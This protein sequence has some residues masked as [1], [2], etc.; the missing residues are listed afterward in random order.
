MAADSSEPRPIGAPR[1]GGPARRYL[2][3]TAVP[4]VTAHPELDTPQ[5]AEDV[6]R[7][8]ELFLGEL[9]YERAVPLGLDPGRDRLTRALR[10]FARSPDRR[11]EDYL[12]CYIAAHGVVSPDSG[13]HHLL[14]ADSDAD[15]LPGTALRTEELITQLWEGTPLERVLI[16][17]DSCHAEAGGD[18]AL[19][20]ALQVRRYRAPATKST[21]TGLVLISSSRRKEYTSPGALSSAFV[22]A[23]RSSAT[24]GN[25]PESISVDHIM[26]AVGNDPRVPDWQQPVLSATQVSAGIPAFLPNPRHVPDTADLKLDEIDRIISLRRRELVAREAELLSHFMPRAR[27]TDVQT[28]EVWD[29]TGRHHVL[30]DLSGWLASG[31]TADRFCVVTGDPGSG[32][33]SVLGLAALLSDPDRRS[34]VPLTGLPQDG[35]PGPGAVDAAVHAGHKSTRQVLDAV[36]AAA[37]C[38][39][40]SVGTLIAA[41]QRR[42]A[43]LVV[44]VDSVDEAL[45]PRE[46]SDELLRPLL[47]PGLGLPLRLLIGSRRHVADRLPPASLRIDLDS[48]RYA[49][50]AAVRAYVRKLLTA[51]GAVTAESDDAYVDA[52][53]GAVAAAAGRSFLV[54]RITARTIAGESRLPDPHDR[55]WRD[56]LPRLPGEAMERDLEQRLGADAERARDLLVPLAYSQGAGLPWAGV[57]PRLASAVAGR[58]YGDEDIVW[59]REAAGSYVVESVEDGGS[60]YRVYHRALIEYL[61]EGRDATAVQRTVTEVLR[62][63]VEDRPGQGWATAHPYVRHH[64]VLHAAEGGLLDPLVQDA[65]FVLACDPGELIAALP[66]LRTSEGRQAGLAI[67]ELEQLLR[68]H[69]GSG[70]S[71]GARAKLRLA[72]LCRG[73]GALADSC[74]RSPDGAPLPWRARWAVWDPSGGKR[75]YPGLAALFGAVVRL[76]GGGGGFVGERARGI[77]AESWDLETG[78]PAAMPGGLPSEYLRCWTTVPQRAGCA[79]AVTTDFAS[80][81]RW[82]DMERLLS[83]CV[84]GEGATTWR[85]PPAPADGDVLVGWR[86]GTTSPEYGM[87]SPTRI[88]VSAADAGA[89]SAAL[90]FAGPKVLVYELGGTPAL[91]RLTRRERREGSPTE[92]EEHAARSQQRRGRLREV[93]DAGSP[94]TACGAPAGLPAD[95]FLFGCANGDVVHRRPSTDGTARLSAV[96]RGAVHALD[97]VGAHP[98]GRLLVSAGED[99]TVCLTSLDSQERVRTLLAVREPVVSIAAH[100]VGQQWLVAA[101]TS[102]GLLHRIDLDSGRPIGPPTRIGPPDRTVAVAAF[103]L[104]ALHCVSV[105]GG[106]RGLQLYDLLSGDRVGG[107]VY[108]HEASQ[109]AEVAAG[110]CVGGSDGI[111]R[112][113][114]TEFASDTYEIDAHDGPVIALGEVRGPGGAPAVVTVGEDRELRCWDLARRREL[115]RRALPSALLYRDRLPMCAV[116]GQGRD[117]RDLVVTGD[118]GGQVR[119][120]VSRGGVVLAEQEFRVPG[121]VTALCTGRVRG[122]D[123]VVAGTGSSGSHCWDVTHG[124]WYARWPTGADAPWTTALA[125][126]PDGSGRLAVAGG[127]GTFRIWSLPAYRPLTEPV[128]AHRAD[129]AAVAFTGTPETLRLVTAGGD[130]RLAVWAVDGRPEGPCWE[131]HMPVPVCSLRATA[132]GAVCGDDHGGVWRLRT[133]DGDWRVAEAV[134]AVPPV[135]GV[136]LATHEGRQ[137][138]VSG[139]PSRLG[140]LRVYDAA[141]G[142]LL[143]RLRPVCESGVDSLTSVRW[144]SSGREP[145]Q[146]LFSLSSWGVLEYWDLDDDAFRPRGR[147]LAVPVPHGRQDAGRLRVVADEAGDG[148][149]LL[150]CG[151]TEGPFAVHDVAQGRLLYHRIARRRRNRGFQDLD[152][153][154]VWVVRHGRRRLAVLETEPGRLY[155]LDVDR[156][157]WASRWFAADDVAEV[158]AVG[159][160][161]GP[162]ILVASA[163]GTA[164]FGLHA[165]RYTP[166]GGPGWLAPTPVVNLSTAPS[167]PPSGARKARPVHRHAAP[168]GMSVRHAALLPGGTEY[169]VAGGHD[170]AVLSVRGG[171][172]LRRIELP[173]SCTGLAVDPAGALAVGSHN[174]LVLFD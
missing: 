160:E 15:D 121:P 58:A 38:E 25:A 120:L 87:F 81:W 108:L 104:G 165:A 59:L 111:V 116:V 126:A 14:L 148:E 152:I 79:A 17:L 19:H 127:D 140:S 22:R 161:A 115:W 45:S 24:A 57:W 10:G 72:A 155:V 112:I 18:D 130:Q 31:R 100:H 97:L 159:Q 166:A 76:P 122:R 151:P 85:L 21:G 5:L 83:V 164:V 90:C 171:E 74:D 62:R 61:R 49:D 48:P 28:D 123:V 26:A 96:H 46:L 109:V 167:S 11:P 145:R 73:A 66:R 30:R 20:A 65:E 101:A 89:T 3:A 84:R 78:E 64:L 53:A 41:L 13:G 107:K 146:L 75:A 129:I 150:V 12:V 54:A 43:P 63:G 51:P 143:R 4:H 142:K 2:L 110:L 128:R 174:G 169:A 1:G 118:G 103:R 80:F 29:F 9:G 162:G 6:G 70:D 60:V 139:Q 71:P 92:L 136:A 138:V 39:A 134:Q 106:E 114:P 170:L 144:R 86:P 125:L 158:L 153:G 50:P 113:W 67:R 27:G 77:G 82:V 32:K 132:D 69:D 88:A 56:A 147:P 149:T 35:V 37:G 157:E 36:A 99:G 163:H 44:L 95:S 117:G 105:Q 135:G 102:R 8:E 137:V 33:S 93:F 133:G 55:S 124:R 173:S 52:V 154:G 91:R 131:R 172:V 34:A 7:I 141:D 23:V 119:V 16:L 68:D 98:R 168:A 94:V 40:E 156:R 47:D 42:T